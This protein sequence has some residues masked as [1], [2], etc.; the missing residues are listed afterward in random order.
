MARTSIYR[1]VSLEEQ[2]E[3]GNG[4]NA[5]D[6]V[7]RAYAARKAWDVIDVF[8]DAGVS[9]SVGLEKRPAMI[10]AIQALGKGD[11]LLV[12][13]R[14]RI[15]RLDPLPMAMIEAAVR[16]R[17][18]RIVSAAGEG[19]EKDDPSDILMR[20]IIDAFAQYERLIIGARTKSALGA[21]RK[22]G[23][24]CGGDVEYGMMRGPDQ[25]STNGRIVKTVVPNPAEQ[26]VIRLIKELRS[27]GMT[28]VDIGIEL[29][30]RGITRRKTTRWDHGYLLKILNRKEVA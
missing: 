6:D 23:E 25:V 5:Q 19:T 12:A 30:A 27:S 4:L 2:A 15:G 7:C 11:V 1:R 17:G 10:E 29:Q 14:D 21:K 28:L 22:R 3:S 20:R 13:K 8:T 24:K 26:E 18:A 9:G 16:R